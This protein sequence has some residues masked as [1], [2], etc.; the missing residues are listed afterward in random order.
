MARIRLQL[1]GGFVVESREGALPGPLPRKARALLAFLALA[2]PPLQSRHRL[3]ALLWPDHSDRAARTSL[4]QALASV[5]RQTGDVLATDQDCVGLVSDAVTVD[6]H[7]F[8][9]LTRGS[10]TSGPMRALDL[11]RGDLLEGFQ[12]DTPT[13]D[14]WLGTERERLRLRAIAVA[15]RLLGDD[16][17]HGRLDAAMLAATR[18]VGL[19]PLREDAH[20]SLMRLQARQGRPAEAMR[21]YRT[22]RRTLAEELGVS[23]DP[24]TEA[25]YRQIAHGRHRA[26]DLRTPEPDKS[27]HGLAPSEPGTDTDSRL[28][29]TFEGGGTASGPMPPEVER[30][31]VTVLSLE[32]ADFDELAARFDPEVLWEVAQSFD[33][34]CAS[35]VA[36]FGG[37]IR[38]RQGD[39]LV[40]FF[41]HPRADEDQSRRAIHAALAIVDDASRLSLPDAGR[42]SVRIGIAAGV[43]LVAAPGQGVIGTAVRLAD[44]L[45]P[46][47]QPGTIVVDDAVRRLAGGTFHY[48]SLGT[49]SLPGT[50]VSVPVYQVSEPSGAASR[51]DATTSGHLTPLVGRNHELALLLDRWARAQECE[52]QIVLL[53][54]EPGIGK[55]RVLAALRERV[56]TPGSP[57]L[58]F[59]CSPYHVNSALW[60]SI[61]NFERA[62]RFPR[63][64]SPEFKLDRLEALIVGHHGRPHSDV[65]F[66]AAMLSIPCDERYGESAL[67]PQK[68][69]DET[70]RTLVDII[71]AA[72]RRK[73][74]LML[75]EDVHWADPT[76]LE[77]IDLL[78]ERARTLPLLVVLTHR[79]GFPA[80]WT[81]HGNVTGLNLARLTGAQTRALIQGVTGGKRLPEDLVE[82]I[83]AKTD[84]VPLFVEEV[85]KSLL[86]SDHLRDAGTHYEYTGMP[87]DFSVPTTLRDSLMARLDRVADVRTVAQ[88]GAAIGR[89]FRH[90]LLAA[91]A[92]LGPEA[93]DRAIEQLTE[94]GL[95][96]RRGTPPDAIYVFKHALLQDAAY[97]S[98]PGRRRQ[99]LHARIAQAIESRLPDLRET[100]PERLAHHLTAAGM[101]AA[102]VPYWHK[103]AT[104]AMDR[105][106]LADA[107]AHSARGIA[108]LAAL[109]DGLE[110][111]RLELGLQLVR[112]Q[113]ASLSKGWAAPEPEQAFSRARALCEQIGDAP[114][115]FSALWG[116]WA[117]LDVGGRMHDAQAVAEEFLAR[118]QRLG[119]GA[120]LCEGHRIVGEMAYRLGD[121]PA[122]RHHLEAGIRIYDVEAHRGNVVLYGQDSCLTNL[123]Y[124]SW[125]LWLLGHADD[126]R[127]AS[128]RAITLAQ[129]QGRPFGL[130]WAHLFATFLHCNLGE[131]TAAATEARRVEALCTEHGF[132]FWLAFGRC[133]LDIARLHLEADSSA[134]QAVRERAAFLRSIGADVSQTAVFALLARGWAAHGLTAPGLVEVEAGLAMVAKTGE[135]FAEAELHQVR[136]DLLSA[137]DASSSEA[138]YLRAIA[139]AREHHG[140]AIELRAA[141]GLSR[142]WAA[143]G[144]VAEACDLLVP[145]V[146]VLSAEGDTRDLQG[147]RA[148]LKGLQA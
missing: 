90:D 121:L 131:W 30:R 74:A 117:F 18:L 112:G 147:A 46:I 109:P 38:Q 91:A 144:R 143:K 67:A 102:A 107:L 32:I 68:F 135:C 89:E 15:T 80:R 52:G 64:S 146:G 25:L 56:E 118:A 58:R 116:V 119:D 76:T 39:G 132:G 31:Q 60:P 97:D 105:V 137:T 139:I 96:F 87:Q 108:L 23:P 127:A 14:Q 36:R 41:G 103:A 111:A 12:A 26:A 99:E 1:L 37:T 128:R 7:E 61:D 17:A 104:K 81:H 43:V 83:L 11:Y 134:G 72:A 69:K 49:P 75:F 94:A 122:A 133:H 28:D 55:S 27:E 20:R 22:L 57:S 50:P 33:A 85:T 51:F 40:A 120:A 124:L 9:A 34:L 59:Q 148:L 88:A 140:R 10:D 101:D 106:A 130:A 13:F 62:L 21:Q 141:L 6:V 8:D 110:S 48:R 16:E 73:P 84:G 53:S 63:E 129:A 19:D 66:V 114:E 42:L 78:V 136:G 47:A 82:R 123:V 77:A 92:T 86:E 100:E 70:L 35:R 45:R 4:R 115:L 125:V 3:A 44:R 24:A 93:L 29:D 71:D 126:A 54:G 95:A 138:S 98:L 65:R 145:L 113:A 5:R 79:P 2:D 142:L